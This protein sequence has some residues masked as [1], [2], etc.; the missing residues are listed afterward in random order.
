ME[1]GL[2]YEQANNLLDQYIKDPIVKLH[3]IESEAI[4]RDLAKHFSEN[5]EEWG[6]IGLLHD[7]DWDLTKN[8][9]AEHCI[10]AQEILREAG[11]TDYLIE[12]VIS[13]CYGH[14]LVPKLKE[15]KRSTRLQYC[16]VAAET[17]TGLII[18]SALMMPERKL[19]SLSIESL[20]KK[21]KNLK[22][23]AKCNRELIKECE[24]A[25]I[26]LDEFLS[27]AL[28]SLQTISDKLCL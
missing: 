28:K 9:T 21:F 5:E 17:L 1:L 20:Q 14:D 25:G 27:L 22:F 19:G 11:A 7:I 10:K 8:D 2:N 24:L 6:I 16:L 3:C 18:A 4:M 15:F 26:T 12:S 23:A 13:H